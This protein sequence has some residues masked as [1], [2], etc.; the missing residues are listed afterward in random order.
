MRKSIEIAERY[1]DGLNILKNYIR[2]YIPCLTVTYHDSPSQITGKKIKP[3]ALDGL[4]Y[5]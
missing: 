3:S 1:E 5:C 4:E 2:A